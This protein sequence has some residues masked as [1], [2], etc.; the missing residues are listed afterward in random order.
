VTS[1]GKVETYSTAEALP[2]I[3]PTECFHRLH[4]VP[5]DALAFLASRRAKPNVASLAIWVSLIHGETDIVVLKFAVAFERDTTSR[6]VS[7][8]A[9]NAGSQKWVTALGAEEMLLVV[10]AFSE[11]RVIQSDEAFVHD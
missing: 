5:N 1:A 4:A 8:L 10:C 11:L 9:I 3:F 2:M 7:I 6:A